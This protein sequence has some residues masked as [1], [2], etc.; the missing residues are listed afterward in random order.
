MTGGS[1]QG[2]EVSA[3]GLIDLAEKEETEAG[4]LRTGHRQA[5]L[6][7]NSPS[8]DTHRHSHIYARTD[9]KCSLLRHK[10]ILKHYIFVNY[11]I[12]VDFKV[13]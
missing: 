8:A 10:Q 11:T 7:D 3:T 12:G 6:I 2:Q 1:R 4:C 13:D 5:V 9:D